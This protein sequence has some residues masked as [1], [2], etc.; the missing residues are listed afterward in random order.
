MGVAGT[1]EIALQARQQP[2]GHY[3]HGLEGRHGRSAHA[4]RAVEMAGSGTVGRTL[5]ATNIGEED[6]RD[7]GM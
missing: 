2:R 7:C 1:N 6:A 5:W 4:S 3:G